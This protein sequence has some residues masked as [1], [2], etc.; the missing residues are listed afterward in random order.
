MSCNWWNALYWQTNKP[1]QSIPNASAEET[2]VLWCG[3]T[4]WCWSKMTAAHQRASAPDDRHQ[5][6]L[7][8]LFALHWP[9]NSSGCPNIIAYHQR[10]DASSIQSLRQSNKKTIE[11]FVTWP[12]PGVWLVMQEMTC[13][14]TEIFLPLVCPVVTQ[15][16]IN[17]LVH[18]KLKLYPFT[19]LS[20]I[21]R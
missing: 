1:R 10:D 20:V 19:T 8:Y 17:G 7:G 9:S 2:R 21:A 5:T 11:V 16:L 6:G 18:P 4:R 13:W 12:E 14:G 15:L 3:D